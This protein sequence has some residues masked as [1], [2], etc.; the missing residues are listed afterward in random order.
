MNDLFSD[1]ELEEESY[2]ETILESPV[3]GNYGTTDVVV[4]ATPEITD[5]EWND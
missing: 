5:P 4:G 2:E 3:D 1:V